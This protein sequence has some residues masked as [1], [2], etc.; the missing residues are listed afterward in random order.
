MYQQTESFV[1]QLYLEG[2]IKR[3]E[4]ALHLL[5]LDEA[6][7]VDGAAVHEGGRR[8]HAAATVIGEIIQ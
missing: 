1:N 2:Q 8:H 6:R 4:V 3:L 5:Q 7:G